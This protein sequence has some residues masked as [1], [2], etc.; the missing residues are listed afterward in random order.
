MVIAIIIAVV[1]AAFD[2]LSK[3]LIVASDIAT[4]GD[5][6]VIPG[7]LTFVYSENDG[8]A[9]GIGSGF[10]WVY[11]SVTL[12]VCGIM[13]YLMTRND[14]KNKLYFVS[15]GL[16]VGGGIG[17]MIDRIINGYVVDFLSLSLFQL[18][19][20]DTTSGLS[21]SFYSPICNIAD[22]CITAGTICLIVFVIFYLGKSKKKTAMTDNKAEAD[23]I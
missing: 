11:V 10:R 8:M 2:Q 7:I 17:N 16:I 5:V 13:F 22:Y 4:K 12:V 19:S 1:V 18:P 3:Y 9:L 14:F 23:E 21:V 6:T 15:A 20:I